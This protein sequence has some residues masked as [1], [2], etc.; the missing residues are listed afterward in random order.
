M[1][2]TNF[3]AC[4]LIPNKMDVLSTSSCKI[5]TCCRRASTRSLSCALISATCSSEIPVSGSEASIR[6]SRCALTSASRSS[7]CAL[8]SA[9]CFSSCAL[10]CASRSSDL[11]VFRTYGNRTRVIRMNAPIADANRSSVDMLKMLIS[12]LLFFICNALLF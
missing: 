11:P 1:A 10:T 12:R 7:N 6:S 9:N 2:N 3:F 4:V 5:A 8:T